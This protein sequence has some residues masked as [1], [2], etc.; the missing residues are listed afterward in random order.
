MESEKPL[1]EHGDA[2]SSGADDRQ[3]CDNA[4]YMSFT[5]AY[6]VLLGL[7]SLVS[8]FHVLILC[9]VIPYKYVWGGRLESREEMLRMESVSLSLNLAMLCL[10]LVR[11]GVWVA[12]CPELLLRICCCLCSLLFAVNTVGNFLAKTWLEKVLAAPLTFVASVAFFR[13][14]RSPARHDA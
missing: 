4:D 12:P 10:I 11:A 7:L 14:S 2:S 3:S 9:S 1:V 8:V 13:L 6:R 5:T